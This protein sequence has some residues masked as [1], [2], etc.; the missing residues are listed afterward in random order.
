MK[1][2]NECLGL[3]T[4]TKTIFITT[5]HKPDGDAIGSMMALAHYFLKKGH[6]V[7]PVSPSEV[8]D[9]LTWIPGIELAMNYEAEPKLV[10]KMIKKYDN[11]YS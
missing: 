9:F 3:L 1:N 4:P 2:I 5:H 11:A 10:E 6:K 8:P 7:H